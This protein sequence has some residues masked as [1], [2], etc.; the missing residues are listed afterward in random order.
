[1]EEDTEVTLQAIQEHLIRVE[2]KI[3]KLTELLD[4]SLKSNCEKMGEHIDFVERVYENVKNPLG[5]VC[6]KVRSLSGTAHLEAL[7]APY[8]HP[9]DVEDS[10]L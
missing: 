8:P 2:A 6:N 9:E 3:D 5:Y 4:G 10:I 7:D 1:M